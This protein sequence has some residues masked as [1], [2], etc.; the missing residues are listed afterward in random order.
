M[1]RGHKERKKENEDLKKHKLGSYDDMVK[2]CSEK[3]KERFRRKPYSQG[4]Q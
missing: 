4:E 2:R 1:E 3:A